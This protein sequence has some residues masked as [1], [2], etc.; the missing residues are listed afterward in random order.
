MKKYSLTT[1][2]KQWCEITLYQIKAEI[3][4]SFMSKG[5]LGGYIEKE[6]IQDKLN[7]HWNKM[8][9]NSYDLLNF[10]LWRLYKC[11]RNI[12]ND[13]INETL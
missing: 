4:F 10:E 8:E 13:I 9:S 7:R 2:T 3:S 5:D 6:E 11:I 12:N 1:N